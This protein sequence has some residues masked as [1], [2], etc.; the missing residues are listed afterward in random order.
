MLPKV[1]SMLAATAGYKCNVHVRPL[2]QRLS[3]TQSLVADG[4][5]G[6]A[7]NPNDYKSTLLLLSLRT[8]HMATAIRYSIPSLCLFI[9]SK[10]S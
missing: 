1:G 8:C 4:G 9:L 3:L 7:P 10:T 6:K 2:G 5:A